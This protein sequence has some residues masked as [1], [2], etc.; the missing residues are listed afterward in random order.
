MNV[1]LRHLASDLNG[2]LRYPSDHVTPRCETLATLHRVPYRP[3]LPARPAPIPTD[4][5]AQRPEVKS[6]AP[7]SLSQTSATDAGLSDRS[8]LIHLMPNR[9]G[10]RMSPPY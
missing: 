7:G 2:H 1:S 10:H 9:L 3:S 5:R 6:G 8:L 4:H